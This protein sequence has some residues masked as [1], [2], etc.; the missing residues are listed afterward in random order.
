MKTRPMILRFCFGIGNARERCQELLARVHGHE[1]QVEARAHHVDDA[2]ELAFA[3][4]A[5]VHE[6]AHQPLAE[7]ALAEHRGDR[8]IDAAARARR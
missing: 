5:V 4:Q 6:D 7:R 8:R 2:L 3:E 1:V